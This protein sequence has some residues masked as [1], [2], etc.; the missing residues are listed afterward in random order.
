[1]RHQPDKARDQPQNQPHDE[2]S[3][4]SYQREDH[5][6]NDTIADAGTKPVRTRTH[7]PTKPGAE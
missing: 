4:S 7:S 6:E 5:A 1:M 3:G 2:S